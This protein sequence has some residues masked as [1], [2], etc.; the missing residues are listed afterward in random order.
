V[1]NARPNSA[2]NRETRM[3][4]ASRAPRVLRSSSRRAFL[5]RCAIAT[6]AGLLPRGLRAAATPSWSNGDPFSLGVAAGTPAA[7]GC[8]LWTRLAPDPLSRDPETPGGVMP[9]RYAVRYEIATDPQMRRVVQRGEAIADPGL[10]YSVHVEVTGLAAA[11]PYWY[12]FAC[13]AAQSRIGRVSTLPP[14]DVALARLRLGFVSCANYEHGY[15]AAYRHLADETPDLA[16]FLGDY[17]YEFVD[18]SATKVRTHSDGVEATTLPLYRNRY[19]Q[20]RLD[21]DLQRLHAEVPCIVTWDDHEV[22]NDYADRW[23]QT[24]DDPTDFLRRRAAAYQAFYEHMPLRPSRSMPN[25]PDMRIYDRFRFGQLAE[26][27]LLDGR[28]YRSRA[29]CWGPPDHGGNRLESD[30]SCP[31]LRDP[32]R[33]L[34]GTEQEHWLFDGLARSPTRWNLIAQDVLMAELRERDHDGEIRYWVDDWNGY[35]A[36]R[37]RLLAHLHAAQVTNPI[38]V[39]G[40][41]HSFWA[42]DLKLDFADPASPVVASEFV[43]TSVSAHPPPYDKFIE[44]LPD[45]PHVRYFESR[46]RGYATLDIEPDRVTARFRALTDATMA[47]TDVETLRAFVVETGRPGPVAA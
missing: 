31:A 9:A 36:A 30:A 7:D 44:F 3:T 6:S 11:R 46:R 26:V 43:G 15:F 12:R 17:I 38:V 40:D 41:I 39:S 4:L 27:S 25:G 19:A 10:A 32:D 2:K 45:N 14:G 47:D 16:I 5:Q 22:Q 18:R 33:S 35:P 23:A 21:P 20:Y 34:L 37:T 13:G 24:F 1:E 8:V 28:Q 29:A 42:N